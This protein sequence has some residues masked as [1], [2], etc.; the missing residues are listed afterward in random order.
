MII[1]F[2]K[3]KT[4]WIASKM[5]MKIQL[6]QVQELALDIEISI[7]NEKSIFICKIE[8]LKLIITVIIIS[9]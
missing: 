1:L 8:S 3:R 6:D 7:L 9:I 5:E 2:M 4:Q